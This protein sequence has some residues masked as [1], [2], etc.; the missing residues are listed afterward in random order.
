MKKIIKVNYKLDLLV[1]VEIYLVQYIIILK[2][3]YREHKLLI[4][5]VDTYRGKEEDK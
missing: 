2:L 4:Y 5:K 3:V 1:K